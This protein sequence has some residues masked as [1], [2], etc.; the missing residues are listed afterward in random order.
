M[1]DRY[2][3]AI[4]Q[5][6]TSSRCIVFDQRGGIVSVDQLEH[7]Q[8]FP[9]P[10]WVEHDATELWTK[11]CSVVAG[12][13]ERAGLRPD[14]LSAIGITNQ[15][16]TTL[17]W[18]RAT[19][20]PVHN[21]I[22]WQDTRTSALCT[23]LGGDDGQD[24]FRDRTGL[25]LA[26]YFAGPKV[27]W[28]LDNVPGLRRRAE[29][30]E[31][32]FGTIDSWLIWN[33]TGG[34]DGGRHVTD[35]TN[36]SRTMLMNLESLEWDQSVLDAM[37][38]PAAVLPEIRSSSE[39]Y[40]TAVGQLAGVPVA[41][42]LGDQQAAVFGQTC[43][44]VGEAKNTYGTGSFLLLN[45][46]NRP[47]P[48]KN[49][50]LT[51]MG[52]RLGDEPPVYCLE[53]SI[54]ITGALVQW[55]R[56]QLGIIDDA[57]EIEAL[58]ASVEDN[59]GAYIVPAFSGLFA[60]YWRSDARG[61]VTGLTRYVTKAHLARA[62][63]EATSWQTREVVDAMYQDSGVEITTL[64]VDGGMTANG[65]LMQ[66]QADVL[67]V[68]VIRPV[69]AETTCLGAAYAAGLATGVWS[70]LDELRAHWRQDAEWT[71][72]MDEQERA[73]EYANWHKAVERS[74]GWER[75]D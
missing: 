34:T 37:R 74:F 56:D 25:P 51:T 36:A 66:H 44:G 24:R 57:A 59:G 49:G 18:D 60:P 29:N 65:L 3:A 69:V 11:V 19:G 7:R 23:E 73:R 63:L 30:G 68:P 52:Y 39:V 47:V 17:L 14:Q 75:T 70:S 50:L 22:V 15:R 28:L 64:K 4:D 72:R 13:L 46:G 40:G 16:E 12:A 43:Y 41:S 42:A 61:V 58:A 6:T 53:G 31:I 10:G 33:L 32:A 27:A 26:S 20:E 55:F 71:P 8:I 45:T 5:G 21:A 48:S 1:T 2:V 54:A 35:V 38:V 67:G 62:V 9:K